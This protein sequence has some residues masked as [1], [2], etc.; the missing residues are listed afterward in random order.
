MVYFEKV[1]SL[2]GLDFRDESAVVGMPRRAVGR[3][4]RLYK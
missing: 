3:R 2:G 1:R 4:P